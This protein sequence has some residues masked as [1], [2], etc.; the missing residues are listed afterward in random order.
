VQ[1]CKD[2]GCAK[3]IALLVVELMMRALANTLKRSNTRVGTYMTIALALFG[4]FCFIKVWQNVTVEDLNRQNGEMRRQ[5]Q[6][7]K[8]D[9][10]RLK[11][12]VDELVHRDRINLIAQEKLD[13][14]Q[15]PKINLV[16][17]NEF[18]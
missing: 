9:Q 18:K 6:N 4:L 15:A 5:L 17:K 8:D 11:A 1:I 10:A 2:E 16:L 13:F 3:N 7:I 12:R 14:R